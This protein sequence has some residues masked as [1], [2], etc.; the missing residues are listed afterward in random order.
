MQR[1]MSNSN[2]SRLGRWD[3]DSNRPH[4][5][6]K[7]SETTERDS[8]IEDDAD[9]STKMSRCQK[10]PPIIRNPESDWWVVT[11]Y[12]GKGSYGSVHLAV[13]TTD[14]D[15]D[16]LPYEIVIK[17]NEFSQASRITNEERLLLR[18]KSPFVVSCYGHEITEEKNENPLSK[19]KNM[20]YNTILEY[21]PGQCLAKHIKSQNGGGLPEDDV[22]GF[23]RDILVGLKCIHGEKIIHCDIKPK[24]ILLTPENKRLRPSGFAVKISGFGKAMETESIE[25]GEGWGHRRGTKRFMSPE[26]IGDIVL[27]YGADVWAFGCTVLEMLTGERAW[28]EHG[29]L[30]WEDWITLIGESNAVPYVPDSL[31]EEAKDFLSKC[32]EKDP[33]QRW[34]V[35]NL[36]KHPFLR[37]IDPQDE[38]EEETYEEEEEEIY[39]EEDEY[40]EIGDADVEAYLEE[41]EAFEEEQEAIEIDEEYPKEDSEEDL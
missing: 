37:W 12:L 26:L 34:S 19:T 13:S 9:S 35:D 16:Y 3:D 41:G 29:E 10:K 23:A 27:D 11:E 38:E 25:Y 8:V 17:S 32:L 15:E 40:D 22:K 31:S 21:C 7:H 39:E 14:G 1:S 36:I 4:K 30:D 5:K 6:P 33:A 20:Y 18:L 28:G 2:H 24:N